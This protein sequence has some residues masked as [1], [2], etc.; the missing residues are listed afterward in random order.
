MILRAGGNIVFGEGGE[1]LLQLL[2][3]RNMSRKSDNKVAITFQPGAV[4]A[5]GG[6]R[7]M[8][9]PHDIGGFFKRGFRVHFKS[10]IYEPLFV[11]Q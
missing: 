3:T 4:T 11:Y 9:S 10:L 8:F 6:Q 7:K 5:F 2:F 1:K